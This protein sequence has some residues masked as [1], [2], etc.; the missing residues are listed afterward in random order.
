MTAS[1]V[2]HGDMRTDGVASP[3]T[4]VFKAFRV[5]GSGF[6]AQVFGLDLFLD[7]SSQSIKHFTNF[8]CF[9]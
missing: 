8:G 9:K 4:A 5:Q 1:L 2:P 3:E 7:G 6:R